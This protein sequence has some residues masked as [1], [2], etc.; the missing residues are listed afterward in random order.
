MA[1]ELG[2][3]LK[4]AVRM[5][6]AGGEATMRRFR[7]PLQVERKADGSVV[8]AADRESE[9]VMRE[10]LTA[11]RSGDAVLGEEFGELAGP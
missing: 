8:T 1:D 11:H 2:D 6:H 3:L 4:L 10:V 5:A 9:R 7:Q